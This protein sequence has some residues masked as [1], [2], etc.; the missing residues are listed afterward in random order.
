MFG[1]PGDDC[2]QN[3]PA[4]TVYNGQLP[5]TNLADLQLS[6]SATAGGND[7]ATLTYNGTAYTATVADSLT[8]ISSVWNQA[9]FN[10]VGN[11]GSTEAVLNNGASAWVQT[12]VTDGSMSSPTCV[13]NGGTT[14]ELTISTS[15][16]RQLRLFA[17]RTVGPIGGSNSEPSTAFNI[18]KAS[19]GS[20]GIPGRTAH[21]HDRRELLQFS[22]GGRV[23]RS[24]RSR[25]NGDL[26]CDK[27]LFQL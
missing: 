17:A 13:F 10:V 19:C 21:Q 23:F 6:G 18:T 5:I 4:K 15:C 9:E 25:W 14:G 3:S 22:G 27:R 2:V 8:D 20:S 12:A 26:R 1:P 7:Q 24:A 11:A 16:H